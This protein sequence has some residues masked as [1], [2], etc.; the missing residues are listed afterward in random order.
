MIFHDPAFALSA[1]ALLAG[2]LLNLSCGGRAAL[3]VLDE[4]GQLQADPG[5]APRDE[6]GRMRRTALD[7]CKESCEVAAG[8]GWVDDDFSVPDCEDSCEDVTDLAKESDCLT[9]WEEYV[10]CAVDEFECDAI[11]DADTCQASLNTYSICISN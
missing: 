2:G 5:D 10:S 6:P 7:D 9:E 3:P 1:A 11:F 8:C 4:D